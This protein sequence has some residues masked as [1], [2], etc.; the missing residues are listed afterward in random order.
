MAPPNTD[1]AEG[2]RPIPSVRPARD[3]RAGARAQALGNLDRNPIQRGHQ[4]LPRRDREGGVPR[5]G[6]GSCSAP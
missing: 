1:E 2:Q 5:Q 3:A 4:R 6:E